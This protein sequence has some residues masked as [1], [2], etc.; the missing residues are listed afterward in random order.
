[1]ITIGETTTGKE[2]ATGLTNTDYNY[3]STEDSNTYVFNAD[4]KC[5][6]ANNTVTIDKDYT[7]KLITNYTNDYN[8]VL[9]CYN[10][11]TNYGNVIIDN[12]GVLGLNN[13]D[14]TSTNNGT[15]DII[16]GV[17]G[18]WNSAIL[19]N[20]GTITLKGSS[21]IDINYSS[22][23][24]NKGT[25]D[26]SNITDLSKW[27]NEDDTFTLKGG[28][29]FILPKSILD[30]DKKIGSYYTFNPI[31]LS[32]S[33]NKVNIKGPYYPY[34]DSSNNILCNL[35]FE[36]IQ[37]VTGFTFTGNTSNVSFIP[38][39]DKYT[40]SDIASNTNVNTTD[41][42]LSLPQE[43]IDNIIN[44]DTTINFNIKISKGKN[45]TITGSKPLYINSNI[46]VYGRVILNIPV[47]GNGSITIHPGGSYRSSKP[48]GI[49]V[50]NKGGSV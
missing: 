13:N 14:Y 11:F 45:V 46:N 8:L 6:K 7:L 34:V 18:L 5:W 43:G 4:D 39:G 3:W 12:Y 20:K 44:T 19:N 17:L 9:F 29:T 1:P 26:I 47:K 50:I 10:T 40:L 27:Y 15:I 31:T 37:S 23:L 28:S 21:Y 38:I 41:N 32:D 30:S 49:K 22:T 35:T 36:S 33:S 25:I 16:N 48:I 42:T 24:T 2:V